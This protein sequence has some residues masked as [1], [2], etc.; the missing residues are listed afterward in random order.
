MEITASR[1]QP[2]G[3]S[4]N[5]LQWK[6]MYLNKELFSVGTQ[7]KDV[8][9]KM[10]TEKNTKYNTKPIMSRSVAKRAGLQ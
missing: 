7:S 10:P 8:I 2:L 4:L 9:Q 5:S 3:Y 1:G 6:Y